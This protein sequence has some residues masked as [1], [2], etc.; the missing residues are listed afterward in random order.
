MKTRQKI[1]TH[2]GG[3]DDVDEGTSTAANQPQEDLANNPMAAIMK[4]MTESKPSVNRDKLQSQAAMAMAQGQHDTLKMLLGAHDSITGATGSTLE[5][6]GAVNGVH[7]FGSGVRIGVSEFAI[8]KSSQKGE[9]A[10]QT[11]CSFKSDWL[12]RNIAKL[13]GRGANSDTPM[14]IPK[15]GKSFLL[16]VC[17]G[18]GDDAAGCAHFVEKELEDQL[19]QQLL[20]KGSAGGGADSAVQTTVQGM[21]KAYE[22]ANLGLA[23][24]RGVDHRQSGTAA[25]LVLSTGRELVVACVGDTKAVLGLRKK[26]SAGTRQLPGIGGALDGAGEVLGCAFPL[27][28]TRDHTLEVKSERERVEAAGGVIASAE[29]IRK[30]AVEVGGGLRKRHANDDDPYAPLAGGVSVSLTGR[31]TDQLVER[32]WEAS[33]GS[34]EEG[35]ECTP[36]L[37]LTRTLG[38]SMAHGLG[39]SAEPEVYC[40]RLNSAETIEYPVSF[41]VVASSAVWEAIRPEEVVAM[42]AVDLRHGSGAAGAAK[43]VLKKAQAH[44]NYG[45]SR[46]AGCMSVSI[47][48]FA[49]QEESGREQAIDFEAGGECQSAPSMSLMD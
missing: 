8:E 34:M 15:Q 26:P 49:S 38:D 33:S 44:F 40:H 47:V 25:T 9:Q 3:D 41:L 6:T 30:L 37:H 29:A 1:H 36:G 14:H 39:V 20:L 18:H 42:I 24:A 11:V 4:E 27:P 43:R 5:T 23:V 32:I 7:G 21:R 46:S 13:D 22:H 31:P 45:K 28:I 17:V 10:N 48:L 16:T 12:E 19:F 2:L 35:G